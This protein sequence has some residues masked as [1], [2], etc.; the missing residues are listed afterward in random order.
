MLFSSYVDH[1]VYVLTFRS[2][3]SRSTSPPSIG[4]LVAP[5]RKPGR[6]GLGETYGFVLQFFGCGE[7]HTRAGEH[8]FAEAG[9]PGA[10]AVALEEGAAEHPL[11]ALE[12]RG[13][14]RLCQPE[15]GRGFAHTSRV[16]DRA[17]DPE[18]P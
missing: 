7:K 16:R 13:Q 18:V 6:G 9:G 11:D 2:A 3:A 15:Q 12:L 4:P 8:E 14:G 5:M 10:V 17:D 1:D